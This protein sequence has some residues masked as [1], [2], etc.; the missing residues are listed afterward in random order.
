MLTKYYEILGVNASASVE[1]LKQAYRKRAKQL[2]PDKNKGANAHE[3]FVLLSEAYDYLVKF[4]SGKL[5]SKSTG[6]S[7]EEWVNQELVKTR[8][9]AAQQAKMRYQEFLNSDEYK[10]LNS[11]VTIG[12]HL[13]FLFAVFMFIILPSG[14]FY[15]YGFKGFLGS[16]LLIVITLPLSIKGIKNLAIIN[17]T[18][19][20]KSIFHLIQT[21]GFL[22]VFLTFFNFFTFLKI[23]MQ[24]LISIYTL[25]GVF[26]IPISLSFFILIY[27]KKISGYQKRFY[28]LCIIPFAVNLL[29]LI[30]YVFAKNPVLE[31]YFFKKEM[32]AS[33]GGWQ[34]STYIYL[35]ND[36]YANC[37]GIRSF[38]DYQ[39]MAQKSRVSYV[40]CE[41]F[42]GFRVLTDYKFE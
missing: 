31:T 27:F 7:H 2:H 15:F 1:E 3:Q 30:N 34:E 33:T 29:F 36:A 35:E 40:I 28:S 39:A 26:I 5:K 17:T 6:L 42:F 22:I 20:L 8:Q 10:S 16:L 38:W 12:E 21:K 37:Q 13:A 32:H 24:T 18:K 4:K 25:F 9:R 41:G 23:G 14:A 19:L 11:I